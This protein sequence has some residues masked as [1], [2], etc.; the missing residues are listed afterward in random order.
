MQK[1]EMSAETFNISF[2][3]VFVANPAAKYPKTAVPADQ[4]GRNTRKICPLSCNLKTNIQTTA[5]ETIA[6]K[7]IHGFFLCPSRYC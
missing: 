3:G 6:Y 7:S 5:A 4:R 1:I 2:I